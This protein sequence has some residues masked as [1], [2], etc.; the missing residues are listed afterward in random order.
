MVDKVLILKKLK[1]H[2]KI[3]KGSD[4]AEYLG[5]KP[6]TLSSWYARNS[7]DFELVSRK[8]EFANEDFL[9]TGRDPML[10]SDISKSDLREDYKLPVEQELE[11]MKKL[12]ALQSELMDE[13]KKERD[14]LRLLVEEKKK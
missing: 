12:Y 6:S 13:I 4:F 8:C 5:I 11:L 2:L 9:R 1:D 3:K 7:F 14:R 10:K